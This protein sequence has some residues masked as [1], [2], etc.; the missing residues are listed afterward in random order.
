M[1]LN[2]QS[3][4]HT[5]PISPTELFSILDLTIH[6]HTGDG[7][8]DRKRLP[9]CIWGP[10][11][12]GKTE[13]VQSFARQNR[14]PLVVIHPAQFEEMGDLLGMPYKDGDQTSW[15]PPGWVPRDSGPG[16]LLLDDLNRADA[17]ILN[18]LLAL[19]QEGR[20]ASWSLPD[21]WVIV[22]TANPYDN[23]MAVTHMDEAITGRLFHVHLRFDMT[24]WLAWARTQKFDLQG[25]SFFNRYPELLHEEMSAREAAQ[26]L[27]VIGCIPKTAI[28]QILLVA[29]SMLPLSYADRF[30]SWIR[31]DEPAWLTPQTFLTIEDP[32]IQLNLLHVKVSTDDARR[33]KLELLQD[34]T[35]IANESQ[36]L[37]KTAVRN[38]VILLADAQIDGNMTLAFL[39]HFDMTSPLHQ[40]AVEHEAIRS[41]IV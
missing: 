28:D 19:F 33:I 32:E 26:F 41:K 7:A 10:P 2:P 17:R 12:V 40:A 8:Q 24:G 18:G 16:I 5:H 36:I 39:H 37:T 22:A 20:L 15:A 31:L 38:L 11:G 14:L 21:Q 23:Q 27:Q 3:S 6:F 4:A 30:L 34:L 35:H 13:I 1:A 29:R 25:L 9:L